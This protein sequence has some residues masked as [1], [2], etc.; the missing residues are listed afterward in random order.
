MIPSIDEIPSFVTNCKGFEKIST[1]P[2]AR[3]NEKIEAKEFFLLDL[4]DSLSGT[5]ISEEDAK[6]CKTG[7]ISFVSSGRFNNGVKAKIELMGFEATIFP[8]N[9]LSL[10]KNGSVGVCFY[11]ENPIVC[12][13]DVLVLKFK[14]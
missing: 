2:S 3:D 11:H 10:A 5:Y 6:K 14:Q 13:S 4:F 7:N 8:A 9:C 12:T 1:V